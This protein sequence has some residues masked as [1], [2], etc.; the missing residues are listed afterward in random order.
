M[1]SDQ[2]SDR[3]QYNNQSVYYF[4]SLLSCTLVNTEK[5]KLI[6]NFKALLQKAAE[7][8]GKYHIAKAAKENRMRKRQKYKEFE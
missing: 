2:V 4:Q 6:M 1:W 5:K 3:D 8:K 7:E